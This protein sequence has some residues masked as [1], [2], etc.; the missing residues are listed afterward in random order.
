MQQQT[1][2]AKRGDVLVWHAWLVPAWHADLTTEDAENAVTHSCL[3]DVAPLSW[4]DGNA[5]PVRSHQGRAYY[6]PRAI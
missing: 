6:T 2:R 1:F 3:R 5:P 4:E